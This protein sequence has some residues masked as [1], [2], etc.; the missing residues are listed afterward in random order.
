MKVVHIVEPLAGGM[1]TFLTSLVENLQ[2]HSHI[3]VH[4]NREH[5]TPLPIV[6]KQFKFPNVKFIRWPSAQRS[7]HFKKDTKAFI[8][9]YRILKRLKQDNL[10]DIVHLHCSKGGFLGRMVC[11]LLG[12]QHQVIYTP[13]GAPFM[14]GTSILSNYLYKVLEKL[15]SF[16]GGQV[17]CCSPSEQDAYK[18]IGIDAITI[19]NGIQYKKLIHKKRTY[20]KDNVFRVVTSGRIVDQKD[21]A[22][23]N[24]IATFF[25]E[26]TNFEFIWVGDGDGANLLTAK[27][28]RI[29]GWMPS[30]IANDL[31]VS[32]DV[33]LSTARYEGLPFS[34]LEALAMSMPVLLTDCIGNKD[35]SNNLNGA[36]F[37]DEHEAILRLLQFYN[38]NSMLNLMGKHSGSYCRRHFNLVDTFRKYQG[39]YQKLLMP[40]LSYQV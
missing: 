8:E 18:K 5:I 3:I 37:S 4:G 30:N 9:L 29:T 39:L 38:N 26:F 21:P 36:V 23:F 33:Y 34:V 7:L 25:E 40:G 22:L 15:A 1:V 35:L 10:L 32:A 28:I 16:F 13:N 19:N 11:R 17:V 14:A 24:R 20:R 6:K 2:L 12:L 27:N 31:V